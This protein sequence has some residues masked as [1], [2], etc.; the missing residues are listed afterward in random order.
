MARRVTLTKRIRS[1]EIAALMLS[2]AAMLA[3]WLVADRVF[4]QIP[5]LEDEFAYVWQAQVVAEGRLTLPSPPSEGRF[6]V[7][8]VV[9]YAGQRFGKYP[10]GWPVMLGMGTALGVR[11]LVNPVL[12]GMAVWLSYRLSRRLAGEVVGLLAALLTLLS[13]F[14]LVNSGSLL[15]H[16]LGLAL[17]GAFALGWIEAFVARRTARGASLALAAG[18]F[19]LGLLVLTRPLTAVGV[20]LPFA[21]HGLVLLV[22][23]GR[24]DRRRLLLFA[25][26]AAGIASL[27]LL[28]QYAA[29]GDPLLNLYTLWWPYDKVGFGE[30]I[31]RYGHTLQLARTN[32]EFSLWVGWRDLFGWGAFSW[33]FLPF[34]IWAVRKNL[35]GILAGSMIFSLVAVYLAY[36]I[37]SW[38]FGPRYYFEGLH[39]LTFL[40]AAGI[41]QLGGWLPGG[42][43]PARR[44]GWSKLRPL[45]VTAVVS[46]LIA[47]N[48]VFYL[49]LRLQ[50][51]RHLYGISA[52]RLKPFEA[53]QA[54]GLTPALIVTHPQHWTEYGNLLPLVDPLLESPFV[55]TFS[56]GPESDKVIRALFPERRTYHY[57]FD[58]PYT[59]Y[60]QAK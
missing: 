31:G 58:E 36:W 16:P 5:H 13:P 2:A 29:T 37:G 19:S 39:S 4:E 45:A 15:S 8:F 30:G 3:A 14:F 47:L 12:A 23:G 27:Q 33:I 59:F 60:T 56:R 40:S 34:G 17:S 25:G 6:L 11:S 26:I 24:A 49:P 9:D 55:V 42:A 35:G 48:L 43:G 22:R 7:P 32:T 41:A 20:G 28:W 44:L 21:L 38:L 50:S 51:M 52:S 10:L 57:Y 1:A 54:Q 53:A 46:F 18:A